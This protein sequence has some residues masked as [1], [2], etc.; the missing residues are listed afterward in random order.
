MSISGNTL[1]LSQ[2]L[3][4]SVTSVLLSPPP[5][6][7]SPSRKGTGQSTKVASHRHGRVVSLR[8]RRGNGTQAW[9]SRGSSVLEF[10]CPS[11]QRR[12]SPL[13][14]GCLGLARG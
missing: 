3:R 2:T 12:G 8:A 9:R 11:W 6:P 7:A 13:H 14:W 10:S 5:A 4:G 1:A